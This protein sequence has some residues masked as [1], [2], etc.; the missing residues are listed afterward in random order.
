MV[1][2]T[3]LIGAVG[4][5]VGVVIAPYRL[6]RIYVW[7]DPFRDPQGLGY[8][9]VQSKVAIGSG[10][11]GGLGPGQ[12]L[13]KY[14]YLPEAHTDFAFSVFCQEHGFLGAF[15]L[16]VLFLML[17]YVIY[18]VARRT[19]DHQGFL[20]VMGANFLIVGQAFAIWLWSAESCPS[21]GC[22]YLLLVMGERVLSRHSLLWGLFSLSIMTKCV[23]KKRKP[24]RLCPPPFTA[25]SLCGNAAL[26]ERQV[27]KMKLSFFNF[28]R[29][30][31][32]K[33]A[34]EGP[35]F[36]QWNRP[37]GRRNRQSL[38]N[39]HAFSASAAH[40]HSRRILT[41][42]RD[43]GALKRGQRRSRVLCLAMV[44]FVGAIILQLV[45]LQ[46]VQKDFLAHWALNQISGENLEIVPRGSIVD[47]NGE[48]LAVSVVSRSLAVNP[49]ELVD[50]PDRWPKGQM[51]VR[52]VRQVA[53]NRL[54][55]ILQMPASNS[56]SFLPISS[57]CSFG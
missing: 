29:R 27:E 10:G 48:E 38:D 41:L 7:L 39:D 40:E 20:L 56:W 52:D 43:R 6:N 9:M 45:N 25:A 57:I 12:G 13:G 1:I 53:A 16:I 51:P 37:S 15:V 24:R 17:G 32:Q 42:E 55:P 46:F 33:K 35:S 22:R 3:I 11:F 36:P 34:T 4:A 30:K 2:G 49:Q 14:F 8:Q 26:S 28:F 21:L 23:G 31:K 44:L 5:V 50:D 19:R 47:R 54:S 18:T